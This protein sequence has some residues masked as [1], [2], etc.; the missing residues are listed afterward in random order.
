MK[1]EQTD[2]KCISTFY[3][4]VKVTHLLNTESRLRKILFEIAQKNIHENVSEDQ[5]KH[6]CKFSK[7]F[8]LG[9]ETQEQLEQ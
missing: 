9:Q 7:F 6:V 2:K 5:Q 3:S 1:L 4:S 8:K